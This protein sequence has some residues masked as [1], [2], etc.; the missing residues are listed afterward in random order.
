MVRGRPRRHHRL[1]V[2][3]RRARTHSRATASSSGS[4]PSCASKCDPT[5]SSP[6]SASVRAQGSPC[7][8]RRRRVLFSD[9]RPRRVPPGA[10]RWER[11]REAV[12]RVRLDARDRVSGRF[13][14][15]RVDVG[16]VCSG[17]GAWPSGAS[18]RDAWPPTSYSRPT[19]LMYEAKSERANHIYLL[20]ARSRT[21]GGRRQG[22]SHRVVEE[23]EA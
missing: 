18:S 19:S 5:T 2:V 12:E 1:Q 10:R 23:A 22:P 11:F 6:R 7:A 8:L 3:Q 9:S 15:V 13:N 4:P 21:R 20:Q 14:R 17:S 16:V